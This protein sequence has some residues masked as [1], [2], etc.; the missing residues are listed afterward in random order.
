M[1]VII[2]KRKDGGV[3]LGMVCNE[4]GKLLC[5]PEKHGAEIVAANDEFVS[6][7][8]ADSADLPGGTASGRYDK[9]FFAA[10]T[11]DNEGRTVSIDMPR[12]RGVHME[13]IRARRNLLLVELDIE[14]F[15]GNDVTAVKQAL[16]DLP[17]TFDLTGAKT[18]A[19][20]K[21]L[22]PAEFA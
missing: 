16:R 8:V 9:Y 20:L 7:R 13:Q 17:T 14:Q 22:W 19:A 21:K 2:Y 1:E 3:A 10:F 11:D 5:D 12:A 6:F 18:P 15:K 4:A